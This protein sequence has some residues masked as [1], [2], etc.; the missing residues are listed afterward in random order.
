M[1]IGL[2]LALTDGVL[3]PYLSINMQGVNASAYFTS[4]IVHFILFILVA[5]STSCSGPCAP[6]GLC[7][8]GLSCATA[9]SSGTGRRSSETITEVGSFDLHS[10]QSRDE[11]AAKD[12]IA[13]SI[14]MGVRSALGYG[15]A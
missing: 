1:V 6:P 9:A 10:P 4:Q 14:L 11:L 8:R 15:A 7:T 13:S 12:P 3:G 5:A 2:L